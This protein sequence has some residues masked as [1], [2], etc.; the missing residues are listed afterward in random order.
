MLKPITPNVREA[1]QKSTEV[2]LEETKDVDVSKIIY[3]LES[4]YKIKF[5][6]MEVL[7]KLIKEAL[8]NI[9]FIYC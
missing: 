6:N 9:V 3:I 8:N 4:E 5:F 1:V 2:V 7:Q